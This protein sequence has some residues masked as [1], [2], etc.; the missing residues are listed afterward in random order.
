[1]APKKS[2]A[3]VPE[4]GD[5]AAVELPFSWSNDMVTILLV[6]ALNPWKIPA[7]N[8]A[9]VKIKTR[10]MDWKLRSVSAPIN[11]G[12]SALISSQTSTASG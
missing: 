5:I 8:A 7:R 9:D 3:P 1:M 4:S 6:L 2:A 11:T 10:S 12:H